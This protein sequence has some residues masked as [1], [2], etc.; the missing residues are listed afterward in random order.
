MTI[1][2]NNIS[3]QEA[4]TKVAYGA[5]RPSNISVPRWNAIVK[6][7]TNNELKGN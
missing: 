5:S 4:A 1:S 7:V 3:R 2:D 6:Q